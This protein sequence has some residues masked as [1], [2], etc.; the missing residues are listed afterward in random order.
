MLTNSNLFF[1]ESFLHE[2]HSIQEVIT[3]Q[4]V[5]L[6]YLKNS[7]DPYV[8]S[9]DQTLK[10]L[11][12]FNQSAIDKII[13]LLNV[14]NITKTYPIDSLSLT[15][16]VDITYTPTDKTLCQPETNIQHLLTRVEIVKHQLFIQTNH[17]L[18]LQTKLNNHTLIKPCA[19]KIRILNSMRKQK[20]KAHSDSNINKHPYTLMSTFGHYQVKFTEAG[21]NYNYLPLRH[22]NRQIMKKHPTFFPEFDDPEYSRS[23]HSTGWKYSTKK[24]HQYHN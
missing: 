18:I 4:S 19:L 15:S 6:I 1:F 22:R 7:Q 2:K 21:K 23:R 20:S 12:Q 8:I 10:F 13:Y 5:S 9:R 11:T 17:P 14:K 16:K 24:R 3:M